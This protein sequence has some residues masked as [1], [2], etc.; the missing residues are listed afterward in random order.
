MNNKQA[1]AFLRDMVL[2][3]E[4]RQLSNLLTNW[5]SWLKGIAHCGVLDEDLQVAIDLVRR[6][7]IDNM[8]VLEP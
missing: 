3:Q 5:E 8:E 7:I 4:Q 1:F 2:L 6:A